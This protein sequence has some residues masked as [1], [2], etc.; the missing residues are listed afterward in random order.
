M[1]PPPGPLPFQ[2]PS[3][4]LPLPTAPA[5]DW[6]YVQFLKTD[7]SHHICLG[8]SSPVNR[9]RHRSVFLGR[10]PPT[11]RRA[12]TPQRAGCLGA[13]AHAL[14]PRRRGRWRG[15]GQVGGGS[16]RFR[17]LGRHRPSPP[18]RRTASLYIIYICMYCS[19]FCTDHALCQVVP[20]KAAPRASLPGF[21]IRGGGAGSSVGAPWS[22]PPGAAFTGKTLHDYEDPIFPLPANALFATISPISTHALLSIPLGQGWGF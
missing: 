22:P 13:R 2:D 8:F 17:F 19:R 14:H 1:R 7:N 16:E 15:R 6:I 11:P 18:P 9:P 21:L 4:I 10:P 12:P 3:L 20:I 5:P